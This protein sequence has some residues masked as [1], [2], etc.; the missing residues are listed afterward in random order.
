[1]RRRTLLRG[2]GASL[3]AALAGCT[4]DEINDT[5]GT[6]AATATPTATNETAAVERS[7]RSLWTAYNNE[8]PDG[9]VETFHPESPREISAENITFRGT[10][11][12]DNISVTDRTTDTAAV[13]ATVTVT[14]GSE[15]ITEYHTYELRRHED[16]WKIWDFAISDEASTATATATPRTTDGT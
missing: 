10:V 13:D 4:Q 9:V 3:A 11:T 2:T 15:S 12:I 8:N 6:P 1:M 16:T 14:D 5:K 7:V